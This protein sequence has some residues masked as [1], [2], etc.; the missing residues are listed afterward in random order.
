M[1]D[2]DIDW[3]LYGAGRGS[4]KKSSRSSYVQPKADPPS[5][6]EEREAL[7]RKWGQTS[8]DDQLLDRSQLCDMLRITKSDYLRMKDH[9]DF[10]SPLFRDPVLWRRED[11]RRF[12]REMTREYNRGVEVPDFYFCD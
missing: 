11:V 8:A 12:N 2:N 10:P 4:R 5:S 7:H 1:G 9:R 6:D 3:H